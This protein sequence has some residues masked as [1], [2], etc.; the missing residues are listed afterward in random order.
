MRKFKA[1]SLF[2]MI[3][4]S[5]VSLFVSCEPT[6]EPSPGPD[7]DKDVAV[8]SVSLDQTSA[9]MEPGGTLTLVA[10]VKPSNAKDK[11]VKWSSSD[12]AVA[13]VNN[14]TV[15]AV[16]VGSATITATAGGK[17][18][19]CAIT[20]EKGGIPEGQLPA[21]NEIWY[22]TSD[23]KPIA[24]KIRNQGPQ[25]LQSNTYKNGMGILRFSGP[26]TTFDLISDN[27]EECERITE[28]LL[29]D[30][31]E[32][33]S[34]WAFNYRYGIKELRVPA[35]FKRLDG[36]LHSFYGSYLERFTGNHVSEDGRCV[37]IDGK[38]IAYA[39]A[40]ISSY[41][42]PAGVVKIMGSA[43]GRAKDLKT[44]V[45]PSGVEELDDSAFS[46]SGLETVT[47]PASVKSIHPYAFID[48]NNLKNL[49]GDSEFISAD[50]KFLYQKNDPMQPMTLFFFAGKDDTSYEIPEG[51]QTI[52]FYAF[53]DC[54]KLKSV[55]F[56][57]SLNMIRGSNAFLGCV[58]LEALYG[59]HTTSDH[60]GFITDYGEL[61]ILVPSISDDYVVPD[62]VTSI[63][64]ELFAYRQTLRSVTMGDQV[65]K[66][67][68]YAFSYCPA[69]K[70]VTL[71]AN[72][73]SLGL[74]P[75]YESHALESVYFRGVIPP[76]YSDYQVTA[77][78]NLK[79]YVPSQS[80]TLYSSSSGWRDYWKIMEPYPYTDLPT[81]D[82]YISSDYSK[83]GEVTVYQTA[84][85]GNGVD[86]VFMG[87]AYSDRDVASGKY[88][89]DMKKCAE[90]F[91]DV[92]P[93]KSFRNLFNIYFVTAVS[94]TEGYEHGGRSLG[95]VPGFGTS[96][97]GDDAK[98]FEL[99]LKAVKDESRMEEVLV[100][101]CGNQNL[102]GVV[103]ASGTCFYHDPSDWT[104]KDYA[105]GPSVVYFLKQDD[106]FERTGNVLRHEAGGHGFAKLGDEYFYPGSIAQYDIDYL[107]RVSP[108]RW[109]SNVDMTSDP[110]K[111]KW[112]P[113]LADERYKNEDLGIFEGGFTY[114][115]GVWRPSVTSI[116]NN[117]RGGFNAPSRYTIWYRIHKLAYGKNWN[118]TYEDFA[119]YDAINRNASAGG[120][121]TRSGWSVRRSPQSTPPVVTH[122]TWREAKGRE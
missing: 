50:R 96:I 122:R 111:V 120:N 39:P 117:N 59:S 90:A 23:N 32:T 29:P 57:K 45:I 97:S 62:D 104:G 56:P 28:L 70:S 36:F 44:L 115:Y 11:S 114:Q 6:D 101:V 2:A 78:P 54:D 21:D 40:G 106:S 116:M 81:P 53:K 52:Q 49:L 55:T 14:G 79:F 65:T 92:E 31:V 89:E 22:V 48:C 66:I 95:T 26:I 51:I 16:A 80:F 5:M 37:I 88:L 110:A 109:F 75:F 74:N 64:N 82:Y 91:F 27:P 68:D 58:N 12:Q 18:A 34:V 87:D 30:C 99:A 85:E 33:F 43:F 63:G 35:S 103:L 42:V 61:Q 20:V 102:D 67:K 8:E 19:S 119:T 118:G 86:V 112:A 94:A 108:Y 1:L 72:L 93:Y 10:V 84:K 105:P 113:F 77:A 100:V 121:G 9:T 107:N 60:K 3:A 13:T 24:D 76:T 71:S 73:N 46:E 15:T 7:P 98:C 17:S 38:L 69:L 83:E 41:E 4:F 47:I 25:V